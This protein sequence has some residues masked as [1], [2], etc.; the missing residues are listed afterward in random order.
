[1]KSV[2]LLADDDVDILA[3]L[4]PALTTDTLSCLTATSVADALEV[5]RTRKID[6]LVLDWA[7]DR[8]GAEVLQVA[9]E[10]SPRMP[11][12]AISGWPQEVRTDALLLNVDA[13]LHK[14]LSGKVLH[15]QVTQLLQ[16]VWDVPPLYLPKAA[17]ETLPLEDVK[18]N[19]I[20][21]VVRLL[22]NNVTLAA[23]LLGIHRQTV[24][25]ALERT[26]SESLPLNTLTASVEA[27]SARTD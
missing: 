1:M 14:P 7:L 3:Y 6:L 19:Y 17:A 25:A 18:R 12:V 20:R 26:R 16:R 13:F 27:V 22:D 2:V 10:L 23:K 15:S 11:V 8:S 4:K 24:A 9:R 5:L 21:H